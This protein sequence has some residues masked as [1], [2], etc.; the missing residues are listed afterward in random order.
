MKRLEYATPRLK[1]VQVLKHQDLNIADLLP[2]LAPEVVAQLPS[3][4]AHVNTPEKA[5]HWLDHQ[6]AESQVLAVQLQHITIG[7]LILYE[8]EMGRIHLGY[9]LAQAHWGQGFAKEMIQGLVQT[10][11]QRHDWRDFFAGV[12]KSNVASIALLRSL[13]FCLMPNASDEVQLYRLPLS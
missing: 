6:L 10:G 2:I 9:L 12:S 8:G 5:Q 1:V 13:G 4:F 3:T 7:L 11:R